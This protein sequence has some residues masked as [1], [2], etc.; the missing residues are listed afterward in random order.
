VSL[1][2]ALAYAFTWL[3]WAP[4]WLPAFGVNALPVL[5]YHH[6][7]G[8][9]GPFIAAIIATGREE[10]MT[11]IGCMMRSLVDVRGRVPWIAIGLLGPFLLFAIAAATSVLFNQGD[12]PWSGLFV[13]SEFPQFAWWEFLLFN[14][15]TF[16]IGEEVGWRGFALPRLQR[17][18]SAFVAT[19]ILT[20][21]WAIWH[22]P[23]FLYR[24]GYVGMS[25]GGIIGWF[26]SLL[27]GAFLLTWLFN[28]SRGSLLA[29]VLF[30]AAIDVVFTSDLSSDFVVNVTGALIMVAAVVVISVAG[31]STISAGHKFEGWNRNGLEP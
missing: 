12:L 13:S 1:Y 7:L 31:P 22:W 19:L 9:Y 28:S 18:H 29:V 17:R 5:P 4:L 3:I 6:F 15:F 20:A 10:G 24:P 21:G 23:A 26:V 16:G 14:V 25:A 30:H 27:A 11:G 8:A 2:F